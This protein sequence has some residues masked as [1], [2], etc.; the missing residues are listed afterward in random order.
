VNA[1]S[2]FVVSWDTITADGAYTFTYTCTDGVSVDVRTQSGLVNATC[3]ETLT[4]G[5]DITS[6]E[7][8]IA[9]ER[10]RFADIEYVIAFI[11]Q[12]EVDTLAISNNMI[13]IVNPSIPESD[14]VLVEDT[15][16]EPE[17]PTE[18]EP[19][20]ESAVIEIEPE[21]EP[22]PVTPPV[23]PRTQTVY[24]IPVS[25]P[26]GFVDLS[27]RLISIGHVDENGNFSRR[28]T[29]D[30]DA[31]GAF[32]FE[33]KNIGTKTSDDWDFEARLTSGVAYDAP[34]Q[35]PLKP[36][37]RVLFTLGFDNVGD[38][39]TSRIGA[40]VK[41]DDDI[42]NANNSFTATVRVIE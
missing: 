30:E 24:S 21:P 31:R 7:V 29:I 33:V 6:T 8:T 10:Q 1:G 25:D 38:S 22:A 17:V 23:P 41:S 2:S 36:Q 9:S 28:T 3:G 16:E 19:E 37:E 40:T 26:N 11:E 12:G 20:V 35:N 39:G 18:P 32:Q 14:V 4:L 42:N 15:P 34:L 5:K 13:T 27:A